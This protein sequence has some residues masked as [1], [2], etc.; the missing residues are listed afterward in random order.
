MT[1]LVW[2]AALVLTPACG[3]SHVSPLATPRHARPQLF[4][5]PPLAMVGRELSA[6]VLI[7]T[8]PAGELCLTVIGPDDLEHR[9]SC[10][11]Y[12]LVGYTFRP[13]A[14]GR[15]RIVAADAR[16]VI[17]AAEVCVMGPDDPCASEV[18]R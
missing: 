17:S 16:A 11:P 6:S 7:P 1:R 13:T 3:G 10:A 4:V 18:A 9:R 14:A 5:Y 15:Y 8:A 12:R 2:A